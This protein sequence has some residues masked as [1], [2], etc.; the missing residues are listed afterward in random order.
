M[1]Q[2]QRTITINGKAIPWEGQG[3]KSAQ[4]R[5]QSRH[6]PYQPPP[7]KRDIQRS[8]YNAVYEADR[9]VSRRQIADLIG[10]KKTTWLEDHIERMVRSRHLIR[11]EKPYRPGIN[12]YFYEAAK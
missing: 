6:V 7:L 9:A 1:L 10:L 12:Q 11:T 2:S 4:A 3:N 5:P 8:I